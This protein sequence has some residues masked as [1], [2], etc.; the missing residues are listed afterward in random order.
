MLP[1]QLGNEVVLYRI[2]QNRAVEV[3]SDNQTSVAEAA[4]LKD[5]PAYGNIAELGLG[6]LSDFGIKPIGETLLD[7]KLGL[8]I[9][10]G[11]SEHFGGRIGPSAFSDPSKVVHIDRVYIE[12][13]QPDVKIVEATL[14]ELGKEGVL[15]MKDGKYEVDF[16]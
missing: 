4:K 11:R 6:I 10:F 14:G 7:E 5:E 16:S 9:A 15:L 1:V 12:E 13:L 3:L 8:H 2:E